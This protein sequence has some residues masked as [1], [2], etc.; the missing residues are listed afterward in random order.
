MKFATG[1]LVTGA[2]L[3]VLTAPAHG[4][5]WITALSCLLTAGVLT[6]AVHATETRGWPLVWTVFTMYGGIGFLNIHIEALFF[7]ILPLA[8]SVRDLLMGLTIAFAASVLIVF[9]GGRLP[10]ESTPTVRGLSPRLIQG[11]TW[12]APVAA[13]SYVVLYFAAGIAVF[14]FVQ[15]FYA[16]KPLP[17]PGTLIAMQM[18][19]G[20]VYVAVVFPFV[21]RMS[22]QRW[23]AAW[24]LGLAFSVLGG[25][26]PLLLP[27]NEYLP[28]NIRVAHAVEIGISNFLFGLAVTMLLV[29]RERAHGPRSEVMVHA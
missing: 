26:A 21:Q 12:R 20:L 15:E 6:L 29:P 7:Q 16:G 5:S 1:V 19:R 9:L 2:L 13:F 22:G 28:V 10:A 8:T 4:F 25:I 11:W 17:T 18:L 14:P 3:T 24:V 23:R 27:N